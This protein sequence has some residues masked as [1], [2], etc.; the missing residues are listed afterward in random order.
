MILYVR[1]VNHADCRSARWTLPRLV[2]ST[3]LST[4]TKVEGTGSHH[5]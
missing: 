5:L 2:P 3:K 4:G 1:L